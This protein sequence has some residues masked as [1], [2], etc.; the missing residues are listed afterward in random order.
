MTFSF[1]WGHHINIFT[2]K[3]M[4]IIIFDLALQQAIPVHTP[5]LFCCKM[6][7]LVENN[8]IGDV[9]Y[10]KAH[11]SPSHSSTKWGPKA[12]NINLYLEYV[13]ISAKI[14]SYPFRKE[15]LLIITLLLSNLQKCWCMIGLSSHL[16]CW[17]PLHELL[18]SYGILV[19]FC[20]RWI[21]PTLICL[22]L[23]YFT[24][25]LNFIF[26]EYRILAWQCFPFSTLY[27]IVFWTPLILEKIHPYVSLV[28]KWKSLLCRTLCDPMDYT[29][30]VILQARILEWVA[31]PFSRG[32]SQPG[33]K[34]R[35]PILQTDSLP[36]EPYL[37]ADE[38]ERNQF[39]MGS[40]GCKM[41]LCFIVTWCPKSKYSIS[42]WL[43]NMTEAVKMCIISQWRWFV[44]VLYL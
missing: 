15:E 25:I 5:T 7:D 44:L 11:C 16:A 28:K 37:W 27:S 4:K 17:C 20:W 29:V 19:W 38:L 32:S 40:S 2:L 3:C 43:I 31:F 12:W 18:P 35:S 1:Y 42:P 22:K 6:G 10:D 14:N 30:P 41:T 34:P 36:A 9:P 26:T 8:T 39:L 23:L 13:P 33:I 21:L 24:F